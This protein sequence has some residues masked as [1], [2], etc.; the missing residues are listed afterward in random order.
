MVWNNPTPN[1]ALITVVADDDGTGHGNVPEANEA[2][3]AFSTTLTI[4]P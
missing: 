3:N 4:C 2:D 1:A